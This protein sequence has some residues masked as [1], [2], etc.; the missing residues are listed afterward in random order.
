M[1]LSKVNLRYGLSACL[2][3][4]SWMHDLGVPNNLPVELQTMYVSLWN[5]K[6]ELK[7]FLDKK[8]LLSIYLCDQ[9]LE[10]EISIA[11]LSS[12][13]QRTPR[14]C[15]TVY[16][17]LSITHSCVWF[18]TRSSGVIF[19]FFLRGTSVKQGL[20]QWNRKCLTEAVILSE[21][22]PPLVAHFHLT[23]FLLFANQ[24]LINEIKRHFFFLNILLP[25]LWPLT[26]LL[27]PWRS[28]W[29]LATHVLLSRTRTHFT[30]VHANR[31]SF[32]QPWADGTTQS[33][34]IQH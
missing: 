11:S 5:G 16:S 2:L 8:E 26:D 27:K 21:F 15:G 18:Q 14:V 3:P 9:N 25:A 6:R 17:P 32:C 33:M 30:N 29:W 19:F 28:H 10:S 34:L 20:T 4:R 22:I 1:L 7:G 24:A 13:C 12:L 31:W 23:P